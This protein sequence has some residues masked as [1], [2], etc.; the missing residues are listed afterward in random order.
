MNDS[1]IY[2]LVINAFTK[3]GDPTTFEMLHVEFSGNV[4][5]ALNAPVTS[6]LHIQSIKPGRT[7]EELE[8]QL[9]VLSQLQGA[10]GSHGGYWGRA[11]DT[12]ARVMIL[13]WDSVEVSS[14]AHT[15]I[16]I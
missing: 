9:E 5:A 2:P 7:N 13:G 15:R 8:E 12:D 16:T 3:V 14:Q 4:A 1:K 6:I 10:H 11:V